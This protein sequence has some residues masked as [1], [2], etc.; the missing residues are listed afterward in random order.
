MA[1]DGGRQAG[2]LRREGGCGGYRGP[3]DLADGGPRGTGR[4]AVK[5]RS[6]ALRATTAGFVVGWG[7]SVMV[8]AV[9]PLGLARA[10]AVRN[11]EARDP[12]AGH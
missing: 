9:V 7:G 3:D 2:A 12:H 6:G 10:I 8:R 5:P 4:S 1:W 11:E